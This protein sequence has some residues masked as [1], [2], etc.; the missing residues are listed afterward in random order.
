M[1]RLRITFLNKWLFLFVYRSRVEF[2]KVVKSREFS[3]DR[4]F[5]ADET[6]NEYSQST[7]TAGRLP[8]GNNQSDPAH[9]VRCMQ[10]CTCNNIRGA[11]RQLASLRSRR[12]T[13]IVSY[14]GRRDAVSTILYRGISPIVCILMP[15]HAIKSKQ[16][17]SVATRFFS[18]AREF[19]AKPNI[20]KI[21]GRC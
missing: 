1:D 14:R 2:E 5:D 6:S 17:S 7:D 3:S 12:R 16:S 10:P 9:N 20:D 19:H 21:N 13:K 8:A 15:L 4:D 11:M 18:R